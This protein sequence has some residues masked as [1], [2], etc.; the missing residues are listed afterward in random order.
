MITVTL[1]GQVILQNESTQELVFK[2]ISLHNEAD[3]NAMDNWLS[4]NGMVNDPDADWQTILNWTPEDRKTKIGEAIDLLWTIV[5]LRGVCPWD[6]GSALKNTI[7]Y[8]DDNQVKEIA[9]RLF[10]AN[11]K[12]N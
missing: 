5:G 4:A 8:S 9:D 6:F 1:Q 10:F 2:G 7:D 11:T 12:N 3:F